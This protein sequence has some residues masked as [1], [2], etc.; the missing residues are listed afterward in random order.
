MD[1]SQFSQSLK[2]LGSTYLDA[3]TRSAERYA[4]LVSGAN[5]TATPAPSADLMQQ[6]YAD[7]VRKEGP[8]IVQQLAEASLNYYTVV[9]NAGVEAARLYYEQ[10]LQ[11]ESPAA[12][13]APAS[14]ARSALLFRGEHGDSPSNA[15][16]IANNR[17]EAIDVSFSLAELVSDDGHSRLKPAVRFDPNG[18]RLG[19]NSQQV[20]QC[21]VLLSEQLQPG[22]DYRGQIQV[23]GFPDMAMRVTVRAEPSARPATPPTP[24]PAKPSAEPSG[25]DT[26]GQRVA[27][28]RRKKSAKGRKA[29]A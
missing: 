13:P 28:A 20:V 26:G 12:A 2:R 27:T 5:R 1:T 23:A 6:R 4:A 19:P 9:L 7:F 15:F 16:V 29:S 14:G 25:R 11:P 21:S 10:V 18:C 8:R 24:E 22:V 17:S 3:Y